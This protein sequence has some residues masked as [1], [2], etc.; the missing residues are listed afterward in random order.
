MNLT[1][2]LESFLK[3]P[4]ASHIIP[5]VMG[6][7]YSNIIEPDFKDQRFR[8]HTTEFKQLLSLIAKGCLE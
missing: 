3:K 4:T 8:K 6:G 7:R 5:Y 1:E 2:M